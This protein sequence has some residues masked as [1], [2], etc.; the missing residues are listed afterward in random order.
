MELFLMSLMK[1]LKDLKIYLIMPEKKKELILKLE[2]VKY[3][4][5]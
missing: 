4:L 2:D 5:N 3:S 1:I